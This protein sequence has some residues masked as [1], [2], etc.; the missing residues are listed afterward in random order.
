M[1]KL[2]AI[3][4]GIVAIFAT[5]KSTLLY[6]ESEAETSIVRIVESYC[7]RDIRFRYMVR[8]EANRIISPNKIEITCSNDNK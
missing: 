7:E 1:N 5:V 2:K 4:I 3:I 6:V 8:S